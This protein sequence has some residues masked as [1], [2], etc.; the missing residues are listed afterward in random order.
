[1]GLVPSLCQL[2]SFCNNVLITHKCEW[3]YTQQRLYGDIVLLRYVTNV[4][5]ES[6]QRRV[7]EFSAISLSTSFIL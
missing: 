4:A 7:D 2:H 5:A 6:I 3:F 1:M